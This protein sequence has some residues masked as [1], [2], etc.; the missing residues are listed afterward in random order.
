MTNKLSRKAWPRYFAK[1]LSQKLTIFEGL[2]RI[3]I[4]IANVEHCSKFIMSENAMLLLD[5]VFDKFLYIDSLA[6]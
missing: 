5:E 1:L 6:R 2:Q 3:D 4:E